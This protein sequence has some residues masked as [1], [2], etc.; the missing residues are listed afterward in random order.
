[1]GAGGGG[2]TMEVANWL[3]KLGLEQYETAF[4]ENE[5]DDAVLPSLTAENLKDLGRIVVR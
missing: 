5:I 2:A 1:M 4:R 3:R